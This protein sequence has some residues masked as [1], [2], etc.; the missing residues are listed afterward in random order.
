MGRER[1]ATPQTLSVPPEYGASFATVKRGHSEVVLLCRSCEWVFS[2]IRSDLAGCVRALL[3]EPGGLLRCY[4]EWG[5]VADRLCSRTLF[6]EEMASVE[7]KSLRWAV[8][9][10]AVAILAVLLLVWA[11]NQSPVCSLGISV[12]GE[13]FCRGPEA[14]NVPAVLTLSALVVSCVGALSGLLR[15]R[16]TLPVW[17]AIVCVVAIVGVGA[18]LFSAGFA[19]S[20]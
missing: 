9:I 3:K 5:G 11:W 6:E 19:L 1:T 2:S 7:S 4:F 12:S 14:R 15:W 8:A 16:S 18:T 17:F 13:T 20:L 10:G